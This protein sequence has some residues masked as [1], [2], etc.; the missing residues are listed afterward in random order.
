M[1]RLCAARRFIRISLAACLPLA[2]IVATA[3]A[4]TVVVQAS[5]LPKCCVWKV[6]SPDAT[7]Y[8]AGSVHAL[9]Q[10]DYPLPA[11]YDLAFE[12]STELYFETEQ[13]AKQEAWEREMGRAVRLPEGVKLKDKVDPRTYAYVLRVLGQVKGATNPET[14]IQHLRPWALGMMVES[15]KG[16]PELTGSLG[17]ETYF[18]SK[19][20]KTHKKCLGL[21]SLRQQFG[22][23]SGMSDEDSEILLLL[24]FVHRDTSSADFDRI[25][26]AWKVGDTGSIEKIMRAEYKDSP[27]F[28]QRLIT[29]RN[30]LWMPKL[31]GFL[32]DSRQT[33]L[34]IVGAA[35]TA[36]DEGL[37][38]LLRKQGYQVEQL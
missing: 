28:Y 7:M 15:P 8:I 14:K 1:P 33:R 35:H 20:H 18:T 11:A 22:V 17:V 26:K 21:V 27:S 6:T 25:A 13:D 32:H 3:P 37:P 5:A 16:G 38:A 9:R 31:D 23:L 30:R 2:G 12:H 34:V 29:D 4:D 36:G 24:A 19:A 10:Q